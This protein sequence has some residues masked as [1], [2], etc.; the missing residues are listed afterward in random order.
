MSHLLAR[1]I[2]AGARGGAP[3]LSPRRLLPLLSSRPRP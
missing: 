1:P 2:D 3:S